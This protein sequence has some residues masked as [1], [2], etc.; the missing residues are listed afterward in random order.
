MFIQSGNYECSKLN[1]DYIISKFEGRNTS[2]EE[3]DDIILMLQEEKYDFLLNHIILKRQD[4]LRKYL[5]EFTKG[6]Y[7]GSDSM[8]FLDIEFL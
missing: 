8:K 2:V 4:F 6:K 3:F 1:I 5:S 7:I